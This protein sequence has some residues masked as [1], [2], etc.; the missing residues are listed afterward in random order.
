MT[1]NLSNPLPAFSNGNNEALL[2]SLSAT[3]KTSVATLKVNGLPCVVDTFS[4]T[5]YSTFPTTVGFPA[6]L[7][8]DLDGAKPAH[9]AIDGN[10][11]RTATQD[12][13]ADKFDGTHTLTL[14]PSDGDTQTY[15]LVFTHLPLVFIDSA[16]ETIDRDKR[17]CRFSLKAT[18]KSAFDAKRDDIRQQAALLTRQ[19]PTRTQGTAEWLYFGRRKIFLGRS[20]T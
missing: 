12:I 3:D 16:P 4:N 2:P 6:T 17:P 19:H 7:D 18:A 9:F 1:G 11:Y 15:N 5:V 20:N 10:G 14:T 8:I 13:T